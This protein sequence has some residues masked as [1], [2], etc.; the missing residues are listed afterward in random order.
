MDY[1]QTTIPAGYDRGRDHGPEVL[2]LWMNVIE[3]RVGARSASIILDLGCGTGRFSGCLAIRFGARVVGID[4]SE[5]MLQQ[6]RRKG[7][8]TAFN[9]NAGLRKRYRSWTKP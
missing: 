1:D 6:A 8:G 9:T 3:S 2:D 5:K 7:A 4:P